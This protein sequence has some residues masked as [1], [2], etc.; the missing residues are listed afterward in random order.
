MRDVRAAR[1]DVHERSFKERGNVRDLES[2]RDEDHSLNF[3]PILSYPRCNRPARAQTDDGNRVTKPSCDIGRG[4]SEI[5][6]SLGGDPG[7]AADVATTLGVV[8][9]ARD[10]DV[11]AFR[12]KRVG[13]IGELAR[14]IG[15][16]VE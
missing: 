1:A 12:V 11:V 4:V 7:E 3:A 2:R 9:Q 13:E 8:W 15:E 16:S 14:G 5:A 10:V 6:K